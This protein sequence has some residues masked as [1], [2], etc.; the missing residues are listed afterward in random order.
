MTLSSHCLFDPPSFTFLHVR[1]TGCMLSASGLIRI[2]NIPYAGLYV[3]VDKCLCDGTVMRYQSTNLLHIQR[4]RWSFP[5]EKR[6]GY[7][8]TLGGGM[9]QV[10]VCFY[11]LLWFWDIVLY[12][13]VYIYIKKYHFMSYLY[14]D[15]LK[16]IYT[17]GGSKKVQDFCFFINY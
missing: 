9:S 2:K 16:D 8:G 17:K 5:W 10:C 3:E 4:E 14:I 11:L 15:Y 6:L 1:Y 12:I 13:Y 7:K